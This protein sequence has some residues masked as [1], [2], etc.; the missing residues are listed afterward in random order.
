MPPKC[1]E[2]SGIINQ[3]KTNTGNIKT[4]FE[5]V[6]RIKNRPPVWMSL[7]FSLSIGVI[8]WLLKSIL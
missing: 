6:D 1:E 8:G 7:T 5:S 3:L 2:H 4:L